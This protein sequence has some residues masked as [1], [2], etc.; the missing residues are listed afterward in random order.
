MRIVSVSIDSYRRRIVLLPR[1]LHHLELLRLYRVYDL[2]FLGRHV[3][4][5]S[6]GLT[7][8]RDLRKYYQV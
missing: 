2:P 3:E 7:W 4:F 6:I 8:P 1:C 5:L